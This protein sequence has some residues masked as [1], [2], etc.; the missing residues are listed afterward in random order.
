V[1]VQELVPGVLLEP[2]SGYVWAETPWR[3]S[4]GSVIG[5]YLLVVSDRARVP[6]EVVVRNE[7]VLYLG[8]ADTTTTSPTPG[9]QVVL[10]WGKKMTV[11][12]SSWRN[13]KLNS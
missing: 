3:G 8:T 4:S 10:A 7:S 1:K 11:D 9:R 13:I 12:P 6:E 2:M 5:Q